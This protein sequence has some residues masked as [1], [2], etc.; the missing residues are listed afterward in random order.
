ML[1]SKYVFADTCSLFSYLPLTCLLLLKQ[2]R[3]EEQIMERSWGRVS[4]VFIHF[5]F[6]KMILNMILNS[7][8]VGKNEKLA[9]VGGQNHRFLID[10]DTYLSKLNWSLV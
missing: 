5:G 4:L 6:I 10:K 2:F 9:F 3:T 7:L 1:V 8:H